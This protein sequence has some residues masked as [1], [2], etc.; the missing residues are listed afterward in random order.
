MQPDVGH[1]F[2]TS[3]ITADDSL[4]RSIDTVMAGQ[5]E[6]SSDRTFKNRGTSFAPSSARQ[7]YTSGIKPV[8][9]A[10]PEATWFR[11]S[12]T[13]L[14]STRLMVHPPNPP[15]VIRDP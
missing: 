3:T 5:K 8:W 14:D 9:L 12:S 10:Y 2:N 6:V 13:W 7:T 1:L 15:P 11:K 4:M